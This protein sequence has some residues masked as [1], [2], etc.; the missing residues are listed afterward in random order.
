MGQ[1]VELPGVRSWYDVDGAGDPVVLLH[2]GLVTSETWGPQRQAFAAGHRIFLPERRAHG[3]TPDVDG[4]LSY[5]D[6]SADTIDFIE[7]VVRSPAHLVGWSD[8]GILALLVAIAQPDLVRRIVVIGANTQPATALPE[9]AP[10]FE[11]MSADSPGLAMFRAM[12]EATS[13]DGPDHWPVAVGK[14]LDMFR[15]EPNISSD[16]LARVR[17]PT[18]V[19]V[20]DDDIM[21]LEH[22]IALYRAVPGAELAVVPG[23]SHA[24]LMEKP[25]IA[26]RIILDFLDLDPVP[27]MMPVRRTGSAE[28]H[29]HP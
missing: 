19:M 6:M 16:D 28:S 10:M 11:R 22:T 29:E 26:N 15:R 25:A 27:T 23:T 7:A 4:P 12:Y 2:G 21:S 17:A 3:R 20:G 24:L 8:G 9:M 14:L 18:L 5:D 13:P 1:Y